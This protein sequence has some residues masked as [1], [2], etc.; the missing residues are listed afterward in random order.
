MNSPRPRVVAATFTVFISLTA[1][2]ASAVENEGAAMPRSPDRC[3][4]I[5]GSLSNSRIRVERE[6]KARV[7]FLGGS[8][9]E[10]NGWRVFTGEWLR[11]RFPDTQFDFVN[12]GISSTDSTLAP[13]RMKD[14]VFCRGR[15]DL[16]FFEF[17]V[18]D[19]HNSRT[20]Q[21]S[22][23][24]VEGIIRRARAL[25]PAIDLVTLYCVDPIKMDFIRK[26]KTPPRIV[27]HE[28]VAKHYAIS[29]IDLATEVTMRIDAG[30]FDWKTF[31][32]LHPAPFGHRLY[33]RS[34]GR[35][36]DAAWKGPLPGD[37]QIRPHPMPAEPLDP[38]H[39]GRGRFVELEDATIVKGWQ[40]V[41]RWTAR[42]GHT[43]KQ[44]VNCPMLV[45]EQPGATLKLKFT[46]TAVGLLEVAGPDVG[47]I[48]FRI[49]GGS[50]KRLD[51]FTQWS[52]GLH[53]PWAYMLD[54]DLEPGDHELTLRTTDQQN[55]K[56]RGHACRIVK[57]LAN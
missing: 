19:Q 51:Q 39:Y 44:F 50:L 17:A 34:I 1:P 28:K 49:D 41:P 15:V 7:A 13:F 57:F 56:S 48:E 52:A 35:L 31:G 14:T 45:A 24:G 12:A 37:A 6:K 3:F 10:A 4:V 42:Q 40:L 46:G 21:E 55:L 25:N 5:R 43:R 9:T 20:P 26:G 2:H 32:G 23:R 36:L 18:N 53:I 27:P 30:E 54:T 33:A 29:A 11:K 22:I 8:I 38:H 16:M 47:L